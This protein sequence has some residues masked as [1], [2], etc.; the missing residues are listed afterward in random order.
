MRKIER[1]AAVGRRARQLRLAVLAARELQPLGSLIQQQC[2]YLSHLAMR[3]DEALTM[4]L[5][6][7]ACG[8]LALIRRKQLV[9]RIQLCAR[10]IEGEIPQT[11]AMLRMPDRSLRELPAPGLYQRLIPEAR[12]GSSTDGAAACGSSVLYTT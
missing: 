3:R 4:P 10:Q 2:Q 8:A 1:Q 6:Q 11:S 7:K 5:G 12:R 9:Q